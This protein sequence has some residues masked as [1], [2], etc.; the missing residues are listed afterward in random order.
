VFRGSGFGPVGSSDDGGRAAS[1]FG[2][3][4]MRVC[5]GDGLPLVGE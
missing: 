2:F 5:G 3:K 4:K 1:H